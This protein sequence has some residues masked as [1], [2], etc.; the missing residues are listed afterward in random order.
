M[1]FQIPD[2]L[3]G[4][5]E[6]GLAGRGLVNR[7]PTVPF[8]D[9][10][11]RQDHQLLVGSLI[12]LVVMVGVSL[13][14]GRVLV[15]RVL[16]PLWLIT[17]ATRRISAQNL[18]QRLAVAGPVDEVKELADTGDRLLNASKP[19]LSR[20]TGLSATPRTNCVRR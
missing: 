15:G 10:H 17:A 6:V 18:H 19:H 1:P 16:R 12:A 20:N 8:S 9:V 3:L 5:G 14:L 2:L 11:A 13:L 4:G 7:R